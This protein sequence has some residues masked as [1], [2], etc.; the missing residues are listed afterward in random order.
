MPFIYLLLP[1]SVLFYFRYS[2]RE[3]L[4][5]RRSQFGRE[6]CRELIRYVTYIYVSILMVAVVERAPPQDV[7]V[8]YPICATHFRGSVL[9][10]HQLLGE[11]EP[12][13]V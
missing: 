8:A 12:E 11:P 4:H 2:I 5:Y 9:E 13:G 10:G 6:L 7:V 1:M 3:E